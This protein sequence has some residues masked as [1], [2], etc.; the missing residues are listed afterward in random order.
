MP[1]LVMTATRTA[2]TAIARY[3]RAMYARAAT[4][5]A[6]HKWHNQSLT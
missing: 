5:I 1:S 2:A 6:N 3:P 4:V